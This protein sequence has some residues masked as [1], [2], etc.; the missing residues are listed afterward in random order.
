MDGSGNLGAVRPLAQDAGLA[1]TLERRACA[2]RHTGGRGAQGGGQGG[3]AGGW[4]DVEGGGGGPGW[5]GGGARV[6]AGVA[7]RGRSRRG[8]HR[9]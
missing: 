8:R 4:R 1:E 5:P 3:A 9:E 6:A 7:V 2:C